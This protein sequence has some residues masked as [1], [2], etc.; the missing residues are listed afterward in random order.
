MNHA[1]LDEVKKL[2]DEQIQG[3]IVALMQEKPFPMFLFSYEP[4]GCEVCHCVDSVPVL[5]LPAENVKYIGKCSKCQSEFEKTQIEKGLI[6]P[7]C[8]KDKFETKRVGH[9]D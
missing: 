8:H 5:E 3:K 4:A 9:W 1:R 2:F 6:C 7:I